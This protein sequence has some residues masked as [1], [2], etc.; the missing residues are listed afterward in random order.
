MNWRQLS[1]TEKRLN[2]H[3]RYVRTKERR[4]RKRRE[5][6]LAALAD[7]LGGAAAIGSIAKPEEAFTLAFGFLNAAKPIGRR[8]ARR[9]VMLQPCGGVSFRSQPEHFAV[10]QPRRMLRSSNRCVVDPNLACE[11]V[12][13]DDVVGTLPSAVQAV[14]KAKHGGGNPYR[15]IDLLVSL[16]GISYEL[17]AVLLERENLITE[18][19]TPAEIDA[20]RVARTF[21]CRYR[22]GRLAYAAAVKLGHITP[23]D[24]FA[25]FEMDQL[26]RL[27]PG[28]QIPKGLLRQDYLVNLS[29]DHQGSVIGL[30]VYSLAMTG[31]WRC[32]LG[33][34]TIPGNLRTAR[35]R[36]GEILAE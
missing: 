21:W 35:L 30:N 1:D 16:A 11:R 22:E 20:V 2:A 4:R 24:G 12:P 6:F 23:T 7:Y 9:A 17:A 10:T 31:L 18:P 13:S 36:G 28:V 15:L 25:L 27:L 19:M 33:P 14:R 5:P 8:L 3:G 34:S 26:V 32:P 29:R